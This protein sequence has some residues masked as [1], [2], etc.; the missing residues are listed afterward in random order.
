MNRFHDN[1]IVGLA[2]I[3]SAGPLDW[4]DPVNSPRVY[5]RPQNI[6]QIVSFWGRV[7]AAWLVFTMNAVALKWYDEENA[8]TYGD[9]WYEHH[10]GNRPRTMLPPALCHLPDGEGPLCAENSA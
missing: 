9:C 3:N 4:N 7:K 5:R 10:F 6:R 2:N 1:L 8:H